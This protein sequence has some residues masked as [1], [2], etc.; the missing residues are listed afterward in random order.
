MLLGE[1]FLN[2]VRVHLASE[3][4][5]NMSERQ[6]VSS[7]G[8]QCLIS[9]GDSRTGRLVLNP[10]AVQLQAS[11]R[12]K[13]APFTFSAPVLGAREC[14]PIPRVVSNIFPPSASVPSLS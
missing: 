7:D 6:R 14:A 3:R 8:N 5:E 11:P 1:L 9:T 4:E 13:C 10:L 12:L 2:I